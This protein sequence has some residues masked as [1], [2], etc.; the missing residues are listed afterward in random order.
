MGLVFEQ[1]TPEQKDVLESWLRG[2]SES[3]RPAAFKAQA[4]APV[5]GEPQKPGARFATRLLRILERKGVLT[6]SEAAE[7]LRD[8]NSESSAAPPSIPDRF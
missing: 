5:P 2:D 3:A 1:L 6:H 7:L 8:L 4:P